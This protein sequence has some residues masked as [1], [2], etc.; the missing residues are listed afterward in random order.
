MNSD[1]LSDDTVAYD[2]EEELY[3]RKKTKPH[4]KTKKKKEDATPVFDIAPLQPFD[5]RSTGFQ[6]EIPNDADDLYIFKL[7]VTD[8]IMEYEIPHNL[9]CWTVLSRKTFRKVLNEK[10][11]SLLSHFMGLIKKRDIKQ[12]W[13]V[14]EMLST[15]GMSIVIYYHSFICDNVTHPTVM[16]H[17]RSLGI[18]LLLYVSLF[19]IYRLH[20]NICP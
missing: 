7:F 17:E 6:V 15:Q 18:C 1:P 5:V 13:A 12:Y 16:T 3:K 4:R 19:R 10:V 2:V 20:V 9:V 8:H 14:D 11:C